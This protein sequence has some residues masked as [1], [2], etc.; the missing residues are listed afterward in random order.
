M[1]AICYVRWSS[2]EQGRGSTLERQ[3]EVTGEHVEAMGWTVAEAPMIDRGKSA[4]TGQNIETGNLGKFAK[5]IIDKTRSAQNLVLVV[6]ELDRLSRQPADVMLTWMSPLIRAGLTI[7]VVK[8]NQT[9]NR[10]MLDHDMGGLMMILIGAFGSH[11]ES[12]KKA[13]RVA[14]AWRKKREAVRAGKSINEKQRNHRRPKW[15]EVDE[16]GEFWVPSHK[17]E[18]VELIFAN[19]LK[20]IGKGL[21]AQQLNKRALKDSRFAPWAVGDKSQPPPHWTHTYIGRVLRNRAV[22]GEWQPYTR[23]RDGEAKPAGEAIQNYYPQIIDA[24]DFVRAN[25]DRVAEMLKHQGRSR[26]L[27]NLLGTR[28]ICGECGGQMSARGSAAYFTNKDGEKRRHYQMYCTKAK[29]AKTCTNQRGWNYDRVERPILDKLLTLAMD[30]EYFSNTDTAD[31]E[32]AVHTARAVIDD[33]KTKRARLL[34]LVEAGD[35]DAVALFAKRGREL[36][37]AQ[38]ALEKAE[39][40]L[41]AARGAVSPAE[42]IRRVSEVRELMWDDDADVRFEAR[43][44]IKQALSDIIASITF[45]ERTGHVGVLLVDYMRI[46]TI[47]HAGEIIQDLDMVDQLPGAFKGGVGKSETHSPDGTVTVNNDLSTERQDAADAYVRRKTA[48]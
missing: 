31:L 42:H 19:R 43:T 45:H 9:I 34:S 13:D 40:T 28:A 17:R 8:T 36:K 21:T 15:V 24:A 1:K 4:Y 38:E 14:E 10:A 33:L 18:I 22:L 5:S 41:A 30:D 11:T 2:Q 37:D 35:D 25:D 48:G 27:S 46:F 26:S 16:N 3:L 23:P 47:S 12:R 7:K 32:R 20:G 39:E 29:L 6:E 44:K